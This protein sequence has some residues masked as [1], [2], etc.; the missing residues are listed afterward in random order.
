VE[1]VSVV[2]S[3]PVDSFCQWIQFELN[4]EIRPCCL[5]LQS[6]LYVSI[7]CCLL[8]FS[9]V[10]FGTHALS[11]VCAEGL[12]FLSRCWVFI[13]IPSTRARCPCRFPL[14]PAF[15]V[16]PAASGLRSL[17]PDVLKLVFATPGFLIWS[18]LS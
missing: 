2:R 10:G 12:A 6:N 7:G 3:S 14:L 5:V 16:D 4:G 1:S 18:S 15:C 9:R 13:F 8:W 11:S 17:W